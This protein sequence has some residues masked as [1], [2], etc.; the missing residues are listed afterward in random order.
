MQLAVKETIFFL[1]TL[2][3]FKIRP[4][5]GPRLISDI[6]T[7]LSLCSKPSVL[8]DLS[9]ALVVSRVQELFT[10]PNLYFAQGTLFSNNVN[11]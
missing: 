11:L 4:E 8:L 10:Y 6:Q 7:R 1:E 5:G 2:K 3:D 9:M